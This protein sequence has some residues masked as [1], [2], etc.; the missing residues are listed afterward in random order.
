MGVAP[1]ALSHCPAHHR[2]MPSSTPNATHVEI[3]IEDGGIHGI[4]RD[5]RGRE[6]TFSGWLSLIAA[7]EAC[8]H[9]AKTNRPAPGRPSPSIRVSAEKEH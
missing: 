3:I 9:E 1:D 4:V 2:L 5:S 7:V 8:R 6:T